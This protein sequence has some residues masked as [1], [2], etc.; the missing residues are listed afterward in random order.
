MSNTFWQ[1][2][3]DQNE[4]KST[5]IKSVQQIIDMY[6][7]CGFKIKHILGDLQFKCIQFHMD[8][9][10]INLNITVRDE[11][12][13]EIK[14]FIHIVKESVREIVNTLPFEILPHRLIVENL[15][16]VMFWLNCFPH[17]EGIHPTLSPCTIVTH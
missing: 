9:Q 2:R 11:H 4:T 1:C 17:K 10:G 6:H 16:N 5:I 8:S 15:Y 7:G 3:N 13:Q 14:R 12:V